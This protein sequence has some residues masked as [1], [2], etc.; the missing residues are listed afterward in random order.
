MNEWVNEWMPCCQKVLSLARS[1]GCPLAYSPSLNSRRVVA[2]SWNMEFS[3]LISRKGRVRK[4]CLTW[5]TTIEGKTLLSFV[6]SSSVSMNLAYIGP[7]LLRASWKPNT[8]STPQ[9]LGHVSLEYLISCPTSC[10][11]RQTVICNVTQATGLLSFSE[12]TGSLVIC[13]LGDS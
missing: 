1:M 9:K 3:R 11:W 13:D 12:D 7:C 6:S 8:P 4:D 2:R 10:A 5:N